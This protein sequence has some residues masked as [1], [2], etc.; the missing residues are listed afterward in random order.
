MR[1][2]RY[3]VL[4]LTSATALFGGRNPLC[5]Q[6]DMEL[7]NVLQDQVAEYSR[8]PL[9]VQLDMEKSRLGRS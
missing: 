3:G 1:A 5:V 2:I 8:N 7:R 4:V 9:C 6:L